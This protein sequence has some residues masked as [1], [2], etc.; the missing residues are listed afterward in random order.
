M[1]KVVE[2]N[3]RYLSI[4]NA[5]FIDGNM[6]FAEVL[7]NEIYKYDIASAMLVHIGGFDL[8]NDKVFT[9]K[10]IFKDRSKVIWVPDDSVDYVVLYDACKEKLYKKSVGKLICARGT[11][12]YDGKIY[13]V[14]R[15]IDQ[16]LIE[17]VIENDA[18]ICHEQWCNELSKYGKFK[19][20]EILRTFNVGS[21]IHLQLDEGHCVIYDISGEKTELIKCDILSQIQYYGITKYGNLIYFEGHNLKELNLANYQIINEFECDESIISRIYV[22]NENCMVWNENEKRFSLYSIREGTL[23]GRISAPEHWTTVSGRREK[24]PLMGACGLYNS[25]FFVFPHGANSILCISDTLESIKEIP[26]VLDD[27]QIN[28]IEVNEE[29]KKNVVIETSMVGLKEYIMK[30]T[31]S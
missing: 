8:R 23:L 27:V 10:W 6:Y 28:Y 4:N 20:N 30:L 19:S 2:N 25:H 3:Y 31:K 13:I 9:F 21:K 12:Y 7:T 18:V 17:V 15:C 24:W 16:P 22:I 26:V 5:V 11:I 29:L 14:P 1:I